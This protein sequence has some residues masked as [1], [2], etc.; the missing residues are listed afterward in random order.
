VPPKVKLLPTDILGKAKTN[1]I[2]P[3][4]HR[5]I[6]VAAPKAKKGR[7]PKTDKAV[8][9]AQT[10]GMSPY[11]LR[12]CRNALKKLTT[13]PHAVVFLQP[14]DPVRDAAPKCV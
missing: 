2:A 1:G 11:D 12:A 10:G 5:S 8:V 9:K 3:T 14:V 4:N 13:N 7:P 6:A